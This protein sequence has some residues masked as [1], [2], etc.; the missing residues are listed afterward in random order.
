MF[1]WDWF[2]GVL[3]YLGKYCVVTHLNYSNIAVCDVSRLMEEIWQACVPWF[4][5]RG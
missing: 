5:Q 3:N 1:L 2:S 4:G